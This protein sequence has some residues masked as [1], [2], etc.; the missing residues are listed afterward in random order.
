M[1]RKE[2]IKVAANQRVDSGSEP[3]RYL[4]WVA[5]A[6]WADSNPSAEVTTLFKASSTLYASLA[7]KY[8]LG[9]DAYAALNLLEEALANFKKS[10][11]E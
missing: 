4:S 8:D 1:T 5:G 9:D 11:G 3:F 7:S 2:E 6:K 10:R